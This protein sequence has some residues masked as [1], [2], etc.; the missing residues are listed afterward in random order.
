MTAAAYTF[1][2][3]TATYNRAHTLHRVWES[4]CVQTFRDF[5]W[6]IIDDGSTDG[7]E[8][9]VRAWQAEADFD[10]R[11]MWKPNEGKHTAYNVAIQ[12]A[13]GRFF[14]P[15]DSDDECVPDALERLNAIWESIP[16]ERR[17][18]SLLCVFC[19]AQS[20]ATF[21]ATPSR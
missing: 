17:T 20:T 5:E 8:A 15:F 21:L 13:Q 4:L 1:T 16:Q 7:T 11:Y 2:V 18:S 12:C 10:I 14:I 6:L 3:F 19:A 9:I